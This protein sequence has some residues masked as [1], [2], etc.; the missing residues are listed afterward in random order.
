MHNLRQQRAHPRNHPTRVQSAA[1]IVPARGRQ[2]RDPD[3]LF[4][5]HIVQALNPSQRDTDVGAVYMRG[6]DGDSLEAAFAVVA[7]GG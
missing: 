1:L 2:L 3:T 7:E 4:R 6:Y 5:E